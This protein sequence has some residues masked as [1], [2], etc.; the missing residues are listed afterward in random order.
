MTNP[1]DIITTAASHLRWFDRQLDRWRLAT[2]AAFFAGLVG[3]G[4]AVHDDYGVGWDE[5]NNTVFGSIMLDHI[6]GKN[7]TPSTTAT[8]F[9]TR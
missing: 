8:R 6:T 3:L 4:V 1:T 2:V 5:G 7:P 9:G